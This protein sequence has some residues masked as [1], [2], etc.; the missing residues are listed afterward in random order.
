MF[1]KTNLVI[2]GIVAVTLV[3]NIVNFI[4]QKPIDVSNTGLEGALK[5]LG[6]RLINPQSIE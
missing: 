3:I 6:I 1:A 4:I 5:I 2:F